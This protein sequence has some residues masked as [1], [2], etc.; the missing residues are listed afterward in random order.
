VNSATS[1]DTL[2]DRVWRPVLTTPPACGHRHATQPGVIDETAR[3]LSH[4]EMAVAG[5]LASEG[6]LVRSLPEG[7]GRGRVPDLDVCGVAVEVKS[8]L[9]L[10]ERNGRPPGPRSVLN[11]LIQAAGQAPTVV[12]N[13]FGSGLTASDARR[14]MAR[15]S[16]RPEGWMLSSV[17]VLG[18]GFDLAWS[19]RPDLAPGRA[20]A[21][22]R[23][24]RRQ[25]SDGGLA[26]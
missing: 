6:H 13:G 18:D 21:R 24:V 7:R 22:V 2:D 26:R 5:R 14:G 12:L 19:R 17:R 16:A 25:V 9:S 8:W 15:Y 4:E 20:R 11:K 23:T 1:S 10:A 3:R